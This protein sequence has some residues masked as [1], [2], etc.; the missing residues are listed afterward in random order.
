MEFRILGPLEALADGR[1]LELAGQKP[2]AL[3]A[4]LLLHAN[5]VVSS[6]RLI[7]ALWE[8]SPPETAQKA[9][10]VY[11]SQLRK[12]LG[13]DRIVTR[14]PGYRLDVDAEELDLARFEQLVEQGKPAEAL[15]L[16]RGPPLAD[17]SSHGFAQAEIA[18][19]EEIRLAATEARLALDLAAGRHAAVVGELEALVATYPLRERLRGQLM[20]VL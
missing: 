14:P 12:A 15:S 16:W 7:E 19:L 2:R 9:L 6:D 3:L 10:Q 17:F 13:A 18:R 11:V 5:E 1:A 8:E 4:Y 20:L